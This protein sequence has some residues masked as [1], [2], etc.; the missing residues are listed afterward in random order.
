VAA[1]GRNQWRVKAEPPAR[2]GR[3]SILYGAFDAAQDQ[4][5][6]RAAL[7][8]GGFVYAAVQVSRQVDTGAN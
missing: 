5:A 2:A 1:G 6:G 7:A 3:F 4:L 8:S